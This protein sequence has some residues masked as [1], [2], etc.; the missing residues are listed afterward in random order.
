MIDAHLHFWDPARLTY[1]WLRHVPAIAGRQGPEQWVQ[2]NDG[3]RKA[4][5]VQA[6]CAPEQAVRET[7]WVCGLRHPTVEILGVVAFA[8]LEIGAR[9]RPCL[10]A[11][12][13]RPLV[14]G[15][16]R[17]VQNET[18]GFITA[19]DHLDGLELCAGSDLTIDICARSH[20]LPELIT[21]LSR[22]FDRAPDARVVLDHLGKP[23]IAMH[24]G[25]IDGGG[26]A[27][28]LRTLAAFPNLF[29]KVSGL[30]TQ[31]DFDSGRDEVF[32]PYI[33]HAI[34]C[35]GADRLMYGGDWPVVDLAGGPDRWRRI[36]QAATAGLTAHERRRI[37]GETA[38]DFY[39]L[40]PEHQGTQP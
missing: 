14:R 33:H 8:P 28:N 23:N 30:T 2:V 29:A 4:V 9:A 3:A 38:A 31:D 10:E 36:F 24:G 27:D 32:V 6:D 17:S 7:D 25:D 37:E 40:P 13:K 5:F 35:F 39:R 26:W 15:I 22:L 19:P 12:R 16:R 11:L 18:D 1:D 21:A 34:G 20:Q